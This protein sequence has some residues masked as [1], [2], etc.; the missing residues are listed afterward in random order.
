MI[1]RLM[2]NLRI[3]PRYARGPSE[4]PQVSTI[5]KRK[6][7]FGDLHVLRTK[8][9]VYGKALPPNEV[10][11][12]LREPGKSPKWVMLERDTYDREKHFRAI[13]PL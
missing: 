2:T 3:G 6:L 12:K 1:S 13:S 10:L 5:M 7:F 4:S 9:R 11:V 8:S